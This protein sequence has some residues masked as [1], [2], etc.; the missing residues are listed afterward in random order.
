[1]S[2]ERP[3]LKKNFAG[4]VDEALEGLRTGRGG[5]V[6]LDDATEGS[7]L[8]T[9]VEVFAR[10]LAVCYEQLES[11]YEAGYL[12]TAQGSALDRVVELLGVKRHQAGWLEGDVLF[13]RATP[14]P[15]DI[16]IPAGTLVAGKRVQGFETLVPA[17]LTLGEREVRVPVRSLVPEG[18]PVD[19]DKLS[20]LN[21]PIPGVETVN[22]PGMLLPR[23]DPE[24]DDDLRE[25]AR[26]AIRGG[27]TATASAL[28][29]AVLELGI[30]EV[31]VSEDPAR[32]GRVE[33]VLADLDLIDSEVSEV[34]RRLEEVRPVGVR[35]DVFQATPVWIRLRATAQLDA[36]LG[37]QAEAQM[38]AELNT[39]INQLFDLFEV[40]ETVR[41]NKIRNL[42]AA[43]PRV[44]EVELPGDGD[45]FDWPLRPVDR[46][47]GQP[48]PDDDDG[49]QRLL[50]SVEAPIGVFIGAGERARLHAIELDLQPPQLLVW[51]DVEASYS[52]DGDVKSAIETGI[53]T[54][55]G[56]IFGPEP[57]RATV[58]ASW[59]EL[60]SRLRGIEGLNPDSAR[61]VILHGRDGRVVTLADDP[62][63]SEEETFAIRELIEVRDIRLTEEL[64]GGDG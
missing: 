54:K 61:F 29:R 50:G 11:V 47:S 21:R 19:P 64:A 12:D 48:L 8:R 49:P 18:D 1:M 60:A 38:R 53:R 33:V 10:E 40:N 39:Q 36:D 23:R 9:L 43:H 6:V 30:V 4:L 42:I 59:D 32:P 20:I 37:P 3:F 57:L 17:T 52:G 63:A 7:V 62:A 15:F 25:R 27:Q 13:A 34:R 44:A 55:I 28:E 51:I 22:N 14:A 2:D 58:T 26:S 45:A 56:D 5:R 46:D 35:V 16:D 24:S 31:R 41:W